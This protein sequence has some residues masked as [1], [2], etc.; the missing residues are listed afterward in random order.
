[1]SFE[2]SATLVS[3]GYFS[4]CPLLDSSSCDENS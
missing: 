4:E 2:L 1:M 3:N